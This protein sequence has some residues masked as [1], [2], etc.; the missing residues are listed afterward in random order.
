[1][2]H[3]SAASQLERGIELQSL[4]TNPELLSGFPQTAH[5]LAADPDKS[6]VIFRRFDKVSIRNLLNLEGRVAALE[7]FQEDLDREDFLYNQDEED[8]P[9]V[10]QS[11]ED[12]ALIGTNFGLRE[13]SM[14]IPLQVYQKWSNKREK[15]K[16]KLKE[17]RDDELR[18]SRQPTSPDVIPSGSKNPDTAQATTD[19][20]TNSSEELIQLRWDVTL[21]IKDAVKE[22]RKSP[23]II[24]NA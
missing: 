9:E 23:S 24:T 15:L 2:S 7:A 20:N 1:M 16:K 3:K 4:W 10:A 21:A 18:Q 17:K 14:K 13:N 5:F 22:Y 8:I 19:T 12:F 6:T 11:W